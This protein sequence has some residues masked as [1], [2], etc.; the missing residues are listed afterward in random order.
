MAR[1][2][3]AT[4]VAVRGSRERPENVTLPRQV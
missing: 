4:P 3:E 1:F 2:P